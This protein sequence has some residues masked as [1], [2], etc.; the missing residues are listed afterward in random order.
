[1]LAFGT[2]VE[3]AMMVALALIPFVLTI[4]SILAKADIAQTVFVQARLSLYQQ[5]T[6]AHVPPH[7]FCK[8]AMTAAQSNQGTMQAVVSKRRFL[9]AMILAR[10]LNAAGIG[11]LISA[12]INLLYQL[13]RKQLQWEEQEK[14]K[15]RGAES[16]D[17]GIEG[18]VHQ[19]VQRIST[20]ISTLSTLLD[21]VLA[22]LVGRFMDAFGRM[23][24]MLL[25]VGS[26]AVMRL[27]VATLPS[28]RL[29]IFYR[30]VVAI[31]ANAWFG[32]SAAS[33]SDVFG[34]GS[35][36]FAEA[37]SRVQRYALLAM[38]TGTYAGRFVKEPQ[39]GFAAVGFMQLL[40]AGCVGLCV[41]ETL[42]SK[43]KMDW[44]LNTVSPLASFSFFRKSK[45]LTALAVLC[46]AMELPSHIN[47]DAVYRR[48]K[49]GERWSNEQDSSQLVVYQIS[50]VLSTLFH[51]RL[52]AK[53]GQQGACRLDAWCTV[54]MNLN[55]ALA[56]HPRLLYLN[57]LLG[58]FQCGGLSLDLELQKA[59]A[60][61]SLGVGLLGA[62]TANRSFLPSLVM[63][64]IYTA[65]Y[66]LWSRTRPSAAYAVAGISAVLTAELVVPWTFARLDPGAS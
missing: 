7:L 45:A 37:T 42:P 19:R 34:R 8:S 38:L 44:S 55:N 65:M 23:P 30:V 48:Q 52:I 47:I 11:V 51:T 56:W 32:A 14:S 9:L 35:A 4:L 58:V 22:P 36:A 41:T 1:M 31:T 3:F 15:A 61:A 29:Y 24:T 62:A 63:P 57:P 21:F 59:A 33:I 43:G 27:S 16:A 5:R 20:D 64:R 13:T 18:L 2:D 25:A 66:S 26:S 28:L 49:F 54:I 46:T 53:L 60:A 12:S 40:A 17:E 10:S 6:V 39:Q 50:G